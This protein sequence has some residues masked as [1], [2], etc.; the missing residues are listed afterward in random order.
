MNGEETTRYLEDLRRRL[1]RGD[2]LNREDSFWLI[3]YVC[4]LRSELVNAWEN[5]GHC[6]Y[7]H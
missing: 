7:N 1:S 2:K 4:E 6:E 5:I 3:D